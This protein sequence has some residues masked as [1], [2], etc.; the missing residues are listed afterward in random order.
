MQRV[1]RSYIKKSDKKCALEQKHPELYKRLFWLFFPAGLFY[2]E[3]IVRLFALGFSSVFSVGTLYSLI[4]AIA[5]GLLLAAV[6]TLGSPKTNTIVTT[7]LSLLILVVYG[8]YGVYH[9]I[10]GVCF[11]L[12][13]LMGTEQAV[14]G[15][16]KNAVV[17]ILESL[18]QIILLA[19]PAA[20][21]IIFRKTALVPRK[22]NWK[23][24]VATVVASV[25]A[26]LMAGLIINGTGTELGD[27]RYYY[28]GESIS[29]NEW[30]DRFGLATTVRLDFERNVLGI[31]GQNIEE[32]EFSSPLS[33]G[34]FSSAA[35]QDGNS[36]ATSPSTSGS[37]GISASSGSQWTP[38]G[39]S[40]GQPGQSSVA[41]VMNIDFEALIAGESDETLLKMHKYFASLQPSYKNDYTGLYKGKNLILMTCEGFSP[42]AINET[43]TPTLYKMKTEGYDFTNFYTPL[44]GVSTSDGEYV[45]NVGLIPKSGVWSYYRSGEQKNYMAFSMANL[46]KAEGYCA[47]AYHNNT[48]TYYKRNISHPNMGYIY[49]G[50]PELPVKKSWPESDLEMMQLTMDE[51]I[52]KQPFHAYYMTVSGHMDYTYYDNAMS[53]KHKAEVEAYYQQQNELYGTPIPSLEIRA[54]M[55]CNMELDR[56]LEYILQRLNE[57]GIAENTVIAMSPDH[58]PYGLTDELMDELAGHTLDKTFEMYKGVFLLYCQG[59]QP[60]TVDKL[61]CSLDIIPTICN[62]FGLEYD[63]RL[64]MGSDIFST[65][66]G[67]VVFENKNWISEKGAYVVKTKTFTPVS[68][69][70][71][72]EEYISETSKA[73]RN[74]I[75]YSA[76][77]LDEDYYRK[78]LLD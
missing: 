78:V 55:A 19:V 28:H 44:W 75:T 73:V 69:V 2:M 35:S 8:T 14:V 52:D 57:A 1:K 6:C 33:S 64:L 77:I 71:V 61:S 30:L 45:A 12:N 16:A 29:P 17:G 72:D 10:F 22:A 60:I 43:L 74:K 53:T 26:F 42:Y 76:R 25:L 3:I 15:F 50:Y 40:S 13:S 24:S 66:P 51:Y 39:G 46:L 47:Y 49:K 63:S 58:Y 34:P 5:T 67:L 32:E 31:K 21:F 37:S 9:H 7:V 11:S 36:T 41:N 54:Y 68:G 70:T 20:A 18:P 59:Q 4:Y 48:A 23:F 27:S 38:S 62:L 65:A 56:A